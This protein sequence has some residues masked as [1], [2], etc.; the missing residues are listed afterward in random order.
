MA[1]T[2]S[3]KHQTSLDEIWGDLKNG[4]ELLYAGEGMKKSLYMKLYTHVYNYCTSVQISAACGPKHA[5]PPTLDSGHQQGA[6]LGAE[7][8]GTE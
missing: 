4:L 5:A 2:S 7:F 1:M 6:T 8:V 3:A